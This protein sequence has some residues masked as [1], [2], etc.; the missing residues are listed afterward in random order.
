VKELEKS[1]ELSPAEALEAAGCRPGGA[2]RGKVDGA[3]VDAAACELLR[4]PGT[5]RPARCASATVGAAPS[6]RRRHGRRVYMLKP[7]HLVDDKIPPQASGP[8]SLVTSSRGRQ[9]A[10][11]RQRFGEMEVWALEATARAHA[12]GDVDRQS[13][14]VADAA[15]STSDREGPEPARTGIPESFNVLCEGTPGAGLRSHSRH[16]CRGRRV[17]G[18]P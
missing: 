5:R 6:R 9:G 14:D 10:V 12:P 4:R 16:V 2:A 15:A 18:I 7:S 8:Y 11:R 13:D 3:G 17:R 1:A